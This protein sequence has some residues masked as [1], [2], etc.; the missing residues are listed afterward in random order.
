MTDVIRTILVDPNEASRAALS[1]TLS[2]INSIW[3]S[4]IVS[5]YQEAAARVSE[6]GAHLTIVTLDHDPNPAVELIQKLAAVNTSAVI[7]PASKTSD[8]GLI[9]KAIRAGAREFLTLPAEPAELTEIISR[10][11]KGR[12][13]SQKSSERGPKIITVT[14]ATGGIGCTTLAVNLAT[15]FAAAKENET[16]LLDLDLIFGAVDAYLDIA[17]DHTL[18]HV[19]QNFERLDLTL[20]K[21]SITRHESGLYVLPHP[22]VMQEAANIDPDTLRKLFG[23]L[24][25]AFNMVVVDTSKGLQ[26]ADFTA[27]EMSDVI[28]VVMQLDPTCLRNT[29]RLI[30]FFRECDGLAERVRLVSNRVGSFDWEIGEKKAEEVLKMPISWQI[31]NAAK[32]F[33]EAMLKGVPL[34]EIARGS[35]CHYAILDIARSLRQTAE[36]STK[37]KKGLFAAFF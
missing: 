20:L 22:A 23:L 4:D 16:L 9:L 28:L 8:S 5:S 1:R 24:R 10:L 27:F 35:R 25:A 12:K 13:E 17:P 31:P 21:R 26:S 11:L 36:E 19:V 34:S 33:Q 37:P 30:N 2:G 15:T 7:L 18:T 14:G 3:L 6:I 32:R 29:A